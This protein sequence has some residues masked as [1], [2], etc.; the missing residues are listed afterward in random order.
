MPP[1]RNP[2]NRVGLNRVNVFLVAINADQKF[3]RY[4]NMIERTPPPIPLPADVLALMD[5]VIEL[6]ELLYWVPKPHEGSRGE[7]EAA[8]RTAT[9]RMG[10][11]RAGRSSQPQYKETSSGEER[12][13]EGLPGGWNAPARF[14]GFDWSTPMQ[15][16][17]AYVS[18]LICGH[19]IPFF[20]LCDL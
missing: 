18:S 2:P 3:R 4:Y 20:H 13:V 1:F 17:K 11:G 9:R 10:P 5:R 6:V 8:I 19:G 15:E 16:R 12:G 7:A 14:T